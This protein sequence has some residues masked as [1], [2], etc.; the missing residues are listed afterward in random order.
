MIYR[1]NTH[2]SKYYRSM[3]HHKEDFLIS[4]IGKIKM[5]LQK[6][7]W[8]LLN[9]YSHINFSKLTNNRQRKYK[10]AC[11]SIV[12]DYFAHKL[13]VSAKQVKYLYLNNKQKEKLIKIMNTINIFDFLFYV[14]MQGVRLDKKPVLRGA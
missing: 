13:N 8:E 6:L 11:V 10:E 4:S 12:D 9:N 14:Y 3:K 2:K 5:N 7:L 1:K